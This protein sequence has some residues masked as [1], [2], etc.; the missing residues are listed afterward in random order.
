MEDHSFTAGITLTSGEVLTVDVEAID[1][2][3]IR[4]A[5]PDGPT[6]AP[7][8]DIKAVMLATTDHMLES[9][10]YMLDMS[11]ALR[12]QQRSKPYDADAMRARALGLLAQVAPRLCPNGPACPL[13]RDTSGA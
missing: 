10:G 9:A 4:Y 7:W 5:G 13:A 8:H 12:E 6:S 11:E 1:A 2:E 3:G